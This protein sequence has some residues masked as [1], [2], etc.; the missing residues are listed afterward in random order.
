MKQRA[1]DFQTRRKH[2]EKYNDEQLK[3]YF[4][5]LIDK[6]NEPILKMGKEYTTPA[7]ER[8]ILMRMGFSSQEAKFITNKLF[9]HDLL[10]FGAGH[11]VY[12]YHLIKKLPLR[13]AGLKLLDD[14]NV[15]KIRGEFFEAKW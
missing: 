6:I 2:L 1:D 9:E 12:K 11:V 8:S 5:E 3:T 7:I 4:F 14:E 13:E 10:Q 15:I